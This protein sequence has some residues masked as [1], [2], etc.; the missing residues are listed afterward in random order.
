MERR[1]WVRAESSLEQALRIA[2]RDPAVWLALAR[3]RESQGQWQEA[4][5]LRARACRLRRR[6]GEVCD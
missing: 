1:D 3:L 6:Q 4:E 5:R 2:P